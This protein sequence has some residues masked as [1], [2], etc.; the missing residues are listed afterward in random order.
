VQ[1]ER[2]RASVTITSRPLWRIR[3]SRS[4]PGYLLCACALAGLLASARF[5]LAP[6]RASTP[7]APASEPDLGETAER[8]YAVLFARRYLT[9]NAAEPQRSASALE[10]FAG[11]GLEGAA[12]M[13]LPPGGEQR[14][15][16]AEAV[17]ARQAAPGETVV[18]VAAQT[19]A[20]LLYLAVPVTRA[21]DG[22]LALAGYPAF[23]GAPA[24]G[25]ARVAEHLREVSD[26]ALATV[27]ER[28]LRNYLA[29]AAGELDA[30]L[31]ARARVSLPAAPLTLLS[32]QRLE[33][34]QQGSAVL[35]TVQAQDRSGVRYTL[36]YELEVT[37]AQGRWEISAVETDPDD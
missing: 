16:W 19:T 24:Q 4:L 20:G 22:A 1:S 36:A 37:R 30:D 5:A 15:E 23:V 33:W 11:D 31:S 2:T 18:T 21:V 7:A 6:P 12:G 17:Q 10:A 9:W 27:I 25:P 13:Q 26:P 28:A 8:A 35:A 29:S 32:M 34:A 14:V 3:L